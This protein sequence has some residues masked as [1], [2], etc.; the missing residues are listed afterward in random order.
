MF[1]TK[2]KKDELKTK[3]AQKI[4]KNGLKEPKFS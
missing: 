3:E 2:S 1:I 4:Y